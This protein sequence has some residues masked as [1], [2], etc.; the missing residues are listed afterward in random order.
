MLPIFIPNEFLYTEYAKTIPGHEQMEKWKI[1]AYAVEDL[2]RTHG[3][4]GKNE[5]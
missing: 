5:Q 2:I 4:F 3:N 1:Y